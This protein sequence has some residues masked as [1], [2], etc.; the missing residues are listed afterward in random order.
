MPLL[1]TTTGTTP[2][3]PR[4]PLLNPAAKIDAGRLAGGSTGNLVT[5]TAQPAEL[6]ADQETIETTIETVKEA[7]DRLLTARQAVE[8]AQEELQ[9]ALQQAFAAGVTGSHLAEVLGV[10]TSRVYQLRRNGR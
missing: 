5:M 4:P 6:S 9:E 8:Q 3:V 7:R 10:T 2:L 1:D